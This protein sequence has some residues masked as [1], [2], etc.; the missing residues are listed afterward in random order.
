MSEYKTGSNFNKDEYWRRRSRNLVGQTPLPGTKE[1]LK[2][3]RK[4]LKREQDKK[5]KKLRG[6]KI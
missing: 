2:E 4:L 1:H 3:L 5:F 6:E